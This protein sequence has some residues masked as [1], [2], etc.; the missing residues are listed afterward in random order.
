G[1][2]VSDTG[3]VAYRLNLAS[4]QRQFVWF[5][6]SGKKTG[7]VAQPDITGPANPSLSPDGRRVVLNRTVN[8]N[9]DVWTLDLDRGLFSRLTFD[10]AAESSPV[11]SPDGTRVAFNS[12]RSGVYDLYE[13][14]ATGVGPE[15]LL[16]ATPQNKAP[17]DWSPDGRF[18]LY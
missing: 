14:A 10:A 2:S 16:L 13:K 12:N 8:R 9:T 3:S 7:A 17:V 4:G 15:R 6:R 18:L 11:W 5:D 1:L